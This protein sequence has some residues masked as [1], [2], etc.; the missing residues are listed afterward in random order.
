MKRAITAT[1]LTVTVLVAGCSSIKLTEAETAWCNSNPTRHVNK[2]AELDIDGGFYALDL[3]PEI[4]NPWKAFLA[5]E[6][7]ARACQAAY[8]SR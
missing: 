3:N 2:A 4:K 6:D 5:T 8:L 1:I 7:G